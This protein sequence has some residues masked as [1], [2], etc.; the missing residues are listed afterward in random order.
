VVGLR[1][2]PKAYDALWG[3]HLDFKLPEMKEEKK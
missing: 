3:R 2:D 1:M